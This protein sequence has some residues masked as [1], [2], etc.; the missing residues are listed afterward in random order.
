MI[1]TITGPRSVGKSTISQLLTKRVGLKYVSSDELGEKM[2]EKYGGLDK[3][4]KS[5]IIKKLIKE[6]GYDLIL[7]EYKNDNFVMDLSGGSINSSDLPKASEELRKIVKSKSIVVG[8][9]P[10]KNV[11]ES[12]DFLYAREINRSH[13]KGEDGE[14]CLKKTRKHYRKFPPLLKDF[15][16][17]IVYVKGKS[18][19]DIVEEIE[20]VI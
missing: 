8:L 9:L 11:K 1:I 13:F 6:N 20:D 2:C 12:V 5:G 15:C 18:A 17:K 14:E 10:C 3:A 7:N 16:D 19:V 4:I